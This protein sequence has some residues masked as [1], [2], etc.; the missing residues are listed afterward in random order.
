MNRPRRDS[1]RVLALCT[2]N[3]ARSILLEHA[4]RQRGSGR[5]VAHSAGERPVGRI[6]PE[7]ARL[8]AATGA[9]PA[10]YGS[11]SWDRFLEQPDAGGFDVVITTC[12]SAAQACPFWPGAAVRVHWGMP[13]P[14]AID[15][16]EA[17]RAAFEAVWQTFAAR[18]DALVSLRAWEHS[19]PDLVA[20]FHQVAAEAGAPAAP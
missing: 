19:G 16:P 2:G 10:D 15:D 14:A 1:L 12:D 11:K 6:N 4:F 18:V 8:I 9:D 17:R 20:V 5:F 13:D 7:A 3:S